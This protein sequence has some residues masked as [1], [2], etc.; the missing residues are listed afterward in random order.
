MTFP[1]A[2]EQLEVAMAAP[3]KVQLRRVERMH[4]AKALMLIS[5][6]LV[7]LLLVFG[8]PVL[9]LLT[10]SVRNPEFSSVMPKTAQAI[11]A[12]DGKSLP[13][14]ETVS[15][16]MA[17]LR[18]AR[19]MQTV[20]KIAKRLN[21]NISGF[22]SLLL[23]TARDLPEQSIPASQ[24][25]ARLIGI[26]ERW[27]RTEYWI[28]VK[29]A[30]LPMTDFYLLAA[31]DLERD[32]RGNVAKV[33]S[34]RAVYLDVLFRTF[35]IGLVVTVIT[36]VL[37]YPLAY[38]LAT[39]PTRA[40]NLLM[41]LVLIPF[42]TSLLVRTTAWLVLLQREGLVND[43]L[44]ALGLTNHRIQFVHNR[45]GVYVAMVHVLLP[46]MVLPIYSVMKG[47]SPQYMR[48]A[49][50]LGAGPVLAF[51]EVYLPQ[52]F[53]G[54]AAGCLLVFILSLGYYIT[55]ALVGGP[56]DQMVSYYISY[57][58]NQTINWGMSA[59]LSAVLLLAVLILFV[60]YNR[61][62]GLDSIRLG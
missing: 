58:T 47:I 20:G 38:L 26:D 39:L 45:F 50:S 54:I 29:Q 32:A 34:E 21:Y 56:Q 37:G 28:A 17:E 61:L 49:L 40:S 14:S 18:E 13:S 10:L 19:E 55:P 9:L 52:T 35:W 3:L 1:R 44:I 15:H 30:S 22:R 59:A 2:D 43:A 16:F 31:F 24:A 51:R 41:L 42:Y 12:W 7:F 62:V 60:A 8:V 36:L 46:F 53:P 11:M 6:L 25:L 48:A 33:A 4:K 23:A 5:P 57:F 27:G